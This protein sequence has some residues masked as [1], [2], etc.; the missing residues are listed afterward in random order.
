MISDFATL[1]RARRQEMGLTLA[2]VA[3]ELGVTKSYVSML[4]SS[5]RQPPDGQFDALARALEIPADM[6][7]V[8]AGRLPPDVATA[9]AAKVETIVSAIRRDDTGARL[10]F[11]SELSAEFKE[12]VL[13]SV[14]DA[15]PPEDIPPF[16]EGLR[17]GKNSPAYRAHSY[18]TKVPPEAIEKLVRHHTVEGQIVVDPFCGSGMTGVASVLAGRRAVLS[19]LSPAAVHIARNYT[20]PCDPD[21][22]LKAA[23]RLSARVRPTLS[24]LYESGAPLSRSRVEYTVWS[25]VFQCSSCATEIVYWEGARDPVTGA[26]TEK[27]ACSA[28]GHATAKRDLRW[29]GERPVETNAKGPISR[30]AHPPTSTE[31]DLIQRANDREILHWIPQVP[32]SAAREMWRAAHSAQ[33]INAVADF[34]TKR[35]LHAL[36]A[37]RYEIHEEE[38]ERLRSA[39]LFAFTGMVNRASK[40]YQWNVKRP[41]NVMTGTLYVS[42]L[43]YE[44]NVGSLFERKVRDVA[45]YFANFGSPRGRADVVQASATALQHLPDHSADYVFMDPPFG[46]NIFYA[47]SSLLWDA[48]LGTLTNECDEIVVNKHRTPSKGGKTLLDYQR[49]MT[50]AFREVARVLKASACATLQFNNSSDDVWCAIQEAVHD[51]GLDVRHA[52]GLDK[53]HPSIKGVKGR[54]AKENVASL[55]ALIELRRRPT[56]RGRIVP[57]IGSEQQ[58]RTALLVFARAQRIPFTTD[59]AFASLVRSSLTLGTS[60]SGVSMQTIKAL[61]GALFEPVGTKWSA[62]VAGQQ[63]GVIE[64]VAR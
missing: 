38:N 51:A 58:I 36:S 9:L 24:W 1:L 19:D 3:E 49:L 52:V 2:C 50:D 17:A 61:C 27:V 35:N 30:T 20:N 54:Q 22:F 64:G 34:Y 43:R 4:E 5:Q 45:K 42:S 6:L 33:G 40:R 60:L 44:W 31:L 32:F 46:A 8:A 26:V 39:L 53:I 48:W 18:H 62:S 12:L 55:D 41:T 21:A 11:P 15:G 14:S 37:I 23:A 29:I 16:H 59:E 13:Q 56:S 25:D 47:D 28:C 63:P 10:V 7:R 57:L